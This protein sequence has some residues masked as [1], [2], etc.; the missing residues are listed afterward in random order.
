VNE[1]NLNKYEFWSR[2]GC[3]KKNSKDWSMKDTSSSQSLCTNPSLLSTLI[4]DEQDIWLKNSGTPQ[5]FSGTIFFK[6]GSAK[7]EQTNV[8]ASW[9][10]LFCVF[11]WQTQEQQQLDP[12]SRTSKKHIQLQG[13]CSILT[14]GLKPESNWHLLPNPVNNSMRIIS[15]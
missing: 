6:F 14:T 1:E 5:D 7:P 3:I 9:F 15:T 11:H 8:A 4:H 10:P 13:I 2:H 12:L